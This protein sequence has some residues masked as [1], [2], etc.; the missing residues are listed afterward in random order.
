VGGQRMLWSASKP[1][2]RGPAGG[3][4]I[5]L[6]LLLPFCRCKAGKACSPTCKAKACRRR[7]THQPA[8]SGAAD[9]VHGHLL[10]AI[11]THNQAASSKTCRLRGQV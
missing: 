8:M 11:A 1:R 4:R 10:L 9:M 3:G 6:L 7:S 2:H 5:V